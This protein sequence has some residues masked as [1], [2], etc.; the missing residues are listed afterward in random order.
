VLRGEYENA[1]KVSIAADR[2][3]DRLQPDA[4]RRD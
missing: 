4:M 3:L 1:L 2:L